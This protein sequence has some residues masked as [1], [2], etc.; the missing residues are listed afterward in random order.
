VWRRRNTPD[1]RQWPRTFSLR[2]SV[3]SVVEW[4]IRH[5]VFPGEERAGISMGELR[6][7][8]D[9]AADIETPTEQESLR[10]HTWIGGLLS[11]MEYE[12]HVALSNS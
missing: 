3:E 8:V 10:E 1:L 9:A 7:S 11:I 12:P 4:G 5:H 2:I 6:L